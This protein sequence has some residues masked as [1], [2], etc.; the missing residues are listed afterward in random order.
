MR[1]ILVYEITHVKYCRKPSCLSNKVILN[2]G[3]LKSSANNLNGSEIDLISF[4]SVL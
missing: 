3:I 4:I 1:L 2:Y